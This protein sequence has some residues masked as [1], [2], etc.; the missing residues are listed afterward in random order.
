MQIEASKLI[1]MP[2]GS[3]DEQSKVGTIADIVVNPDDGKLLGF[4]VSSGLLGFNKMTISWQD[5]IDSDTN[6]LV[7]QTSENL[8]PVADNVRI[9]E[10]V[11]D[12]FTLD[13]LPVETKSG[14]RLGNVYDYTVN[15]ELGSL[16]KIFVRQLLPPQD[17]IISRSNIISISK[18]KIIVRNLPAKVKLKAEAAV[19]AMPEPA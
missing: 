12:E 9:A 18:E 6:G 3:I 16:T 17:R 8:M 5:I 4:I 1:D 13:D 7:V 19:S 15:M 14:Q 11:K 10:V 2:V